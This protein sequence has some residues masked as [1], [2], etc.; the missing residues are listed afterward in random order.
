MTPES[1][2]FLEANR[3]HYELW[4]RAEYVKHLDGATRDG[5][6][7]VVQKEFNPGYFTDLWCAT[8][9]VALLEYAY[10]QYDKWKATQ[11]QPT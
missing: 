4:V 9:V 10:T 5:L 6:L 2:D 11:K 1:I 8:C 7:R 3:H